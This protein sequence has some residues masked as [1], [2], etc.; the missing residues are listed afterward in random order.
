MVDA[1]AVCAGCDSMAVDA[2][3]LE[4]RCLPQ[5]RCLHIAVI[6]CNQVMQVKGLLAAKQ[7]FHLFLD[8]TPPVQRVAT[9]IF[10]FHLSKYDRKSVCC[11]G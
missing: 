5:V 8:L 11:C 10:G 9:A 4:K 6:H 7:Y 3:G 2:L 1:A